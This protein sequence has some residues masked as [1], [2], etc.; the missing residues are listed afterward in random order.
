[1]PWRSFDNFIKRSSVR[2]RKTFDGSRSVF[3]DPSSL[4]AHKVV[5]S[6]TQLEISAVEE[7]SQSI[8]IDTTKCSDGLDPFLITKFVKALASLLSISQIESLHLPQCFSI[9]RVE[10]TSSCPLNYQYIIALGAKVPPLSLWTILRDSAPTL[11]ARMNI[12]KGLARAATSL[13]SVDFVYEN[14]RPEIIIPFEDN[15]FERVC[16]PW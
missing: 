13:H 16:R 4:S 6:L 11:D 5:L 2:A 10:Q 3:V 7:T 9:L 8:L 1:M 15:R 12:A 14:V